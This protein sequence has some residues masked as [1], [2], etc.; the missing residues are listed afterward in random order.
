MN[1]DG[2]VVTV[3]DEPA[4]TELVRAVPDPPAEAY[5]LHPTAYDEAE[6]AHGQHALQG[7]S[8]GGSERELAGSLAIVVIVEV[9]L[10]VVE[11]FRSAV[12]AQFL[13]LRVVDHSA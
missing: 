13:E 12:F 1:L 9:Q 11:V 7:Q 3:A 8:R 4:E 10:I 5:T 2:P 6:R